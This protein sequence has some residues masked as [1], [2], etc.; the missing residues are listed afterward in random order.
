[1]T[2]KRFVEIFNRLTYAAVLATAIIVSLEVVW[3]VVSKFTGWL[4]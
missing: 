2:Y 4:I 1:M 3:F